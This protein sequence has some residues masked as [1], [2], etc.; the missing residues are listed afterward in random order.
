[1]CAPV[2][3]RV[4]ACVRLRVLVYVIVSTCD[5]VSVFLCVFVYY[6]RV[7]LFY[8][9]VCDRVH[10]CVCSCVFVCLHVYCLGVLCVFILNVC[11]SVF[12]CVNM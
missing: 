7:F 9:N 2:C 11:A 1:M 12:V 4:C 8:V 3:E 10:A 6:V 5:H